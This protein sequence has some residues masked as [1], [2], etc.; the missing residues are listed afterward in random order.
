MGAELN[1][2]PTLDGWVNL[3]EA[4]EM[5]GF[6]R[7]HAFKKVRQAND[8]DPNGWRT[9]RGVGSEPV[10]VVSIAEIADLQNAGEGETDLMTGTLTLTL[11]RADRE[12]WLLNHGLPQTTTDD[13]IFLAM[14]AG[15]N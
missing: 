3:I 12:I 8:G 11:T 15:F 6:T 10:Y 1:N 2:I 14:G 13:E 5:L 4:D 9:I 7:Q